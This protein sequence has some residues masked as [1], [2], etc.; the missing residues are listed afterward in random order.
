M[1]YRCKLTSVTY[2]KLL[3]RAVRYAVIRNQCWDK[4]TY[5]SSGFC[6]FRL[7]TCVS[8]VVRCRRQG[9]CGKA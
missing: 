5:C 9:G 6:A 1:L 3:C 8:T 7:S 2:F 4:Q